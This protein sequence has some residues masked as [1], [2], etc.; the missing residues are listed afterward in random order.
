MST[1]PSASPSPSGGASDTPRP[2]LSPKPGTPTTGGTPLAKGEVLLEGTFVDGVENCIVLRTDSGKTY[3]IFGG[4]RTL[5]T[6]GTRVAVR[7]VIRTDMAS[8]CM[9]GPIVQVI[10]MRRA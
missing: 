3:E 10:E 7:G 4:D 9:Q 5:H 8:T 1:P 6:V 2:S